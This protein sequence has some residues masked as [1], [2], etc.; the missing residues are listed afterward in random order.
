M[1]MLYTTNVSAY[2]RAIN[3]NEVKLKLKNLKHRQSTVQLLVRL[4][5]FDPKT[6][7]LVKTTGDRKSHSFVLNFLRLIERCM[8]HAYSVYPDYVTAYDTGGTNRSHGGTTYYHYRLMATEAPA[9][10]DDYGIVVGTGTTTPTSEDYALQTQIIHGSSAG[11]LQYGDCGV[12]GAGVVGSN[13]DMV[14]ARTF[15]NGSGGDI[16]IR[17][18]GLYV[19]DQFG[20]TTGYYFCLARDLVN[21]TVSNGYVAVVSYT[22]RTTV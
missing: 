21:Q 8:A 12:S 14:I 1:K 11:Q 17:E 13:V 18:V 22:V 9:G 6:G 10:N 16:T 19:E 15:V 7:K 2:L 5:V 20:Q 3:L 4:D